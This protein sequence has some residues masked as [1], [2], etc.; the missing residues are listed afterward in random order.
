MN[1]FRVHEQ[2][3]AYASP[4]GL[5]SRL[6]L[7]FWEL[8]WALCCRWT[9]KP[10]NAWRVMWLRWFGATIEGAPFVHSRASIIRPWNLHMHHRACLGDGAVAYCLD[11]IEIGP[12]ATVAQGAYLCTGTHEFDDPRLPLKT[13][14]IIVEADAFV[15]LRAIVLPGVTIGIGAI[16]GAGAVLS[17]DA[18][19]WSIYV[20]VP[21]RRS[22]HQ[23][24]QFD[25]ESV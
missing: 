15:G 16:V 1:P 11:R 19:P 22:Q 17:R 13:A 8:C 2:E 23:R 10:M 18:Q 6:K 12:R 4:W 24:R 5:G 25:A 7:Q 14:P 9:P 21:A 20:G 3:D